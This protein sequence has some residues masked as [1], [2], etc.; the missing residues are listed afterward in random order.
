MIFTNQNA[1]IV[2]CIFIMPVNLHLLCEPKEN[3]SQGKE[4]LSLV[5]HG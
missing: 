2:A 5:S 3:V 4:I 1:E